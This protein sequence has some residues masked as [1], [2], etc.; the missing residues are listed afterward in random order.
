VLRD[1]RRVGELPRAALGQERLAAMM[2][3][4]ELAQFFHKRQIA[5]GDVVLRV[6]SLVVPGT[7]HPV[8]FEVRAG[9]VVALAGLVGSGRTELLETIFGARSARGGAVYVGERRVPGGSPRAALAAGVAFV[10]EERHRQ[11]LNLRSTVREN[12]VMGTWRLAYADPGR[13]RRTSR[14]AVRRL[15][16]RTTGV[17]ASIRSLSGGNQQK[18]VV[19]RCLARRPRVLLLDEPTRG[20]DVGAKE[21]IFEL[22]GEMLAQGMAIVFVSSEMREVLGLADRVL[23]MHERRVVGVLER[24]EASEER[25]AYLSAGG[26]E[27]NVG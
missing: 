10:P 20:I 18:V 3:G 17:D 23:V 13:E 14:E 24:G 25:I 19:A 4:R 5:R 9:E 27:A 26:A 21:E 12:L 22:V 15:R 2:V 1:G 8:S 7:S 16:I 6:E 11:G